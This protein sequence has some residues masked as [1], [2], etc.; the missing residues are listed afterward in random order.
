MDCTAQ[1]K[2]R[3]LIAAKL[4]RGDADS[5]LAHAIRDALGG[6]EQ[7]DILAEAI[8]K[9][10]A[11][12]KARVARTYHERKLAE[13]EAERD[14]ARTSAAELE[15]SLSGHAKASASMSRRLADY[16]EACEP[17]R[18]GMTRDYP[19]SRPLLAAYFADCDAEAAAERGDD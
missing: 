5:E 19:E 6:I 14:A 7:A 11:E 18:Y 9:I 8:G 17:L 10:S 16:R 12:L 13:L 15:D 1:D 3:E 2:G 4:Q